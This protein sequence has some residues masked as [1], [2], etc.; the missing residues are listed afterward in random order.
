MNIIIANF[1][2]FLRKQLEDNKSSL[3]LWIPVLQGIGI[4]IYFS[5]ET[6]PQSYIVA[7]I[8]FIL[9]VSL[10]LI[11]LRRGYFISL[12]IFLYY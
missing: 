12:S 6:D 1:I 3:I 8:V 2:L 9:L 11:A 7:C 10:I 4:I 5:L